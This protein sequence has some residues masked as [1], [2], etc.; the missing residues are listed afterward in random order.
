V[1]KGRLK[2]KTKQKVKTRAKQEVRKEGKKQV[3]KAASREGAPKVLKAAAAGGAGYYA[4]KKI[5]EKGQE[6]QAE[7]YTSPQPQ[8]GAADT[9]SDMVAQLQQLAQL[10]DS[11]V[12]TDEEFASAKQKLLAGE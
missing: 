12:L 8:A 10:H 3:T 11:G 9:G 5:S 7:T 1:L 6:D 4:G 2:Q